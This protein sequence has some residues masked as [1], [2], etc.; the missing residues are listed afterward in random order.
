MYKSLLTLGIALTLFGCNSAP[1]T[2]DTIPD[3][4]TMVSSSES[5]EFTSDTDIANLFG[6]SLVG[7]VQIIDCTLSGGTQTECYQFTVAP[8]ATRD[9]AIGPWCPTNITDTD[10]AGGIWPEGGEINPVSGQF[11]ANLSDFYNDPNWQLFDETTGDINVTDS[12]VACAAAARPDVD[13]EY[14]NHCVECRLEYMDSVP[15]VTYTIPVAPVKAS[16]P[17]TNNRG[18]F[19]IAFNGTIFDGSAPTDAILSAYTLAPFDDCG[20][21]INLNAGYHYHEH[22]G[23]SKEITS[24]NHEPI[25]GLALDG[26]WLHRQTESTDLDTCGG[27]TTD[28]EGYHYHLAKTGSNQHLGCFA[29]DTIS[30][31]D[32]RPEHGERPPR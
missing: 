30:S 13:P 11:I 6:E 19:G 3:K 27:H 14:Q 26:Y 22:T 2:T 15:E 10:E 29:G 9:H 4:I 21:H 8:D 7:E 5:A 12:A 32:D 1:T 24:E 16:T 18:G 31:G 25:V 17:S 23:C 20:G 28:A